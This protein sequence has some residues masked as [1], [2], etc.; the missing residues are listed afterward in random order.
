MSTMPTYKAGTIVW[1]DLTVPDADGIRDFYGRVVGWQS[2]P[3]DM[4]EYDDYNI[5]A[6]GTGEVVAGICN[7][8]GT[9]AAIP[10]Q[11]LMY[12]AVPDVEESAR[13]CAELGGQV[14]DGP[15]MMGGSLFCVIRDPA[16]AV[17]GL[18]ESGKEEQP[19]NDPA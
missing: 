13:Q 19:Q 1:R 11:W 7:A 14:V 12:V 15:R 5:I 9:N 18:I 6:Q 2:T 16:G 8:R 10:P 17:L 4:G 3:H